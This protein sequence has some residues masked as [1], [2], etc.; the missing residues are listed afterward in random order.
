M[1]LNNNNNDNVTVIPIVISALGTISKRLI[2]GLED[3]EIRGQVE[4][5]QTRALLRST[6]ILRSVK[7]T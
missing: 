4:N 6:R 1:I 2:K 7:E 3:L 5:S